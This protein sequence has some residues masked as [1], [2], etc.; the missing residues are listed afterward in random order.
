MTKVNIS[1][2]A[3]PVTRLRIS[4]F[5]LVAVLAVFWPVQDHGFVN[6]DDGTYIC[7]NTQ[8]RNGLTWHGVA[9]AF[10][11]THANFWHPLT[12][13][14]HMLDCELYGLNPAGHH[15]TNL[16]LH[17]ANALLLFLVF[18]RMTRAVWKSAVVAALFA[19]HPLHVESVA[20]ASE[21]KDVLSTLFWILTMGAYASYV[22][23]PGAKRYLLVLVCFVL[24]LM[25]KPM[26]VT[27]PFVLLLLDYWP[28]G[29]WTLKPLAHAHP[30]QVEDLSHVNDQGKRVIHLLVEKGPLLVVAVAFSIVAFLAQEHGGATK[31][32]A[33]FP[34]EVRVANALLSYMGYMGKM[35]W[36]KN[37]AVFYPHPGSTLT[38]WQAGLA[39]LLLAALSV[40]TIRLAKKRPYLPVGWLWFLSTFV[41]VIGLV[42]V[43]D[44][45][46]ADRYTYVPLIGLFIVMAWGLPDMLATWPHRRAALATLTAG[47]IAALMICSR[48]QIRYWQDSITL[49]QHALCV[50][51][52]NPLA[53]TNLGVAFAGQGEIEKA[54]WHYG[55][56]LRIEPNYLE[57]RIN[58]GGALAGQGDFD[59]AIGHYLE[60]LRIKPN[61]ADAHYNLGNALARQGNL[62]KAV[63]HYSES[64]CI[65]PDDAEAH[66]NLGITLAAQHKTAEAI[67]HFQK[68]LQIRPDFQEARHN[69]AMASREVNRP[70]KASSQEANPLSCHGTGLSLSLEKK[71]KQF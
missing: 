49:F 2:S 41:P 1:L 34:M 36:P 69:L 16:L 28:L 51:P 13:L 27:L 21:R 5:L 12:W 22:E 53:H 56:A 31:S 11:T 52:D 40:S 32:F 20:W 47:L 37:L 46:M 61:F 17:M 62:H 66:N 63:A 9:W 8:V 33:S 70:A 26:L 23:A 6:F 60:A 38:M 7:N 25:A 10:T 58:L 45:G 43:G 57:A 3:T 55:E 19:L 68:A 67:A 24:G 29:R 48:L 65:K 71:A 14:S 4:L 18:H 15:L 64:L 42:Q 35:L 59:E 44:H 39:G 50:A 54:I 30:P